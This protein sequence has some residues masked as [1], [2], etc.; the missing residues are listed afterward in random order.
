MDFQGSGVNTHDFYN[1]TKLWFKY[2]GTIRKFTVVWSQFWQPG[3]YRIIPVAPEP[4]KSL[5]GAV[6]VANKRLETEAVLVKGKG[7]V[8]EQDLP[9]FSGQT[10]FN[11]LGTTKDQELQMVTWTWVAEE[12]S[13]LAW[14]SS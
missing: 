3:A 8:K 2:F 13:V 14:D 9:V 10:T 6:R 11:I 5:E 7:Q 1:V 12:G 4:P